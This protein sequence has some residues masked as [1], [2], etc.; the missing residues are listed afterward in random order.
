MLETRRCDRVSAID[1]AAFFDELFEYL[2]RIAA[3]PLLEELDPEDRK[4]AS[5]PYLR[6]VL[7]TLMRCIGGVQSM[8]ATHDVL[9]TDETLMAVVGFNAIQVQ[10]GTTARGLSRRRGRSVH[11]FTFPNGNY[12]AS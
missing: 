7:V 2:R 9:L 1:R 3:W 6:F 11:F 12:S 10:Q 5:I 4:R 8:L